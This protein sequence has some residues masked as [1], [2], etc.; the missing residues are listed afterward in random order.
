MV[1]TEENLQRHPSKETKLH[2]IT[3]KQSPAFLTA[4]SRSPDLETDFLPGEEPKIFDV[5]L[6]C[7][8]RLT[9]SGNDERT[10]LRRWLEAITSSG[11]EETDVPR[12]TGISKPPDAEK[13]Q[14]V[15][16]PPEAVEKIQPGS[17][18]SW[19]TN[20]PM[21]PPQNPK[22]A[23]TETKEG[24]RNL[25][26]TGRPT[27]PPDPTREPFILYRSTRK[28]EAAVSPIPPDPP[29]PPL[30]PPIQRSKSTSGQRS[31]A[32]RSNPNLHI[33]RLIVIG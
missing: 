31:T 28:E 8:S 18:A 23:T 10:C 14:R 12:A 19:H 27:R 20:L 33:P 21:F 29:H 25:P 16:E 2:A 11:D 9:C 15:A 4:G 32:R 1:I 13:P 30:P 22:P 24:W 26:R 3:C 6:S 7:T 5:V 17:K